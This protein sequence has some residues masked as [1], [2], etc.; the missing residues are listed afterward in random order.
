MSSITEN[1]AP[2]F[3]LGFTGYWI[4]ELMTKPTVL[5]KLPKA[6]LVF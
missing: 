1:F 6:A 3:D 2:N 4:S 5:L